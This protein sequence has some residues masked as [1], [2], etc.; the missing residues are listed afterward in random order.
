MKSME[1]RVSSFFINAISRWHN[2]HAPS[3]QTL[4]CDMGGKRMLYTDCSQLSV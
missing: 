1:E 3:N 4:T 2:G